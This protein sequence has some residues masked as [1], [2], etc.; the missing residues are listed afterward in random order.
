MMGKIQAVSDADIKT[1]AVVMVEPVSRASTRPASGDPAN[2]WLCAWCLRR[3]A[4]EKDRFFHEGRS[5]FAFDNPAGV[6]FEIITFSPTPGCRPVGVP[7]QEFTWFPGHA[8]ACCLC[9]GCGMHLGW[10]YT[11]PGE[12]AGLI[13][14]RIVRAV[15]VRN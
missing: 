2:D 8:W 14:G 12:F 1:G 4:S 7:T 13:A 9:L 3:V 6:R 5:E 11:G 15:L 10:H